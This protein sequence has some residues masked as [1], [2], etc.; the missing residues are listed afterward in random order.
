MHPLPNLGRTSSDRVHSS[1]GCMRRLPFRFTR[2]AVS[3]LVLA[4]VISVA[5]CGDDGLSPHGVVRVVFDAPNVP[6]LYVG[7]T[8]R[9][10]ARPLGIGGQAMAGRAVRFQSSDPAIAEVDPVTGLV[11]AHAPGMVRITAICEGTSATIEF[12]VRLAPVASISVSPETRDLHPQWTVLLTVALTDAAGRPLTGRTVDFTSSN[13]NVATVGASGLVTAGG[14][15]TAT[16]T[17]TSEAR[18]D[19]VL[20]TVTPADVFAIAISP[21]VRF[22]SDGTIL[23]YQAYPRDERGFTLSD[24]AITW[25]TSDANVAFVSP[26]GLVSARVPGG[27]MITASSGSVRAALP[28]TVRPHVEAIAV[29]P[30]KDTLRSGEFG[31]MEVFLTDVAGN[32]LVDR[33]V[34]VSSSNPGIVAVLSDGRLRA[35]DAG[36]AVLTARA[37]GRTA[38]GAVIVIERVVFVR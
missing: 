31:A 13:P 18:S 4:V 8:V 15:G 3:A 5:A 37:E 6:Q 35:M 36:T 27:V 10:S 17:A 22:M 38:T 23:Q 32:R 1:G 25:K 20:I 2:W 26:T 12:R 14:V 24:R 34:T 29:A 28:L 19:V 33:E 9:L 11:T 16:I 30:A 21:D 7:D